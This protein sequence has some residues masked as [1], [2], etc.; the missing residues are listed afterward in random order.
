MG[1]RRLLSDLLTTK[2]ASIGCSTPICRE[3]LATIDERLANDAAFLSFALPLFLLVLAIHQDRAR[4][5]E[6]ARG[7]WLMLGL[8]GNAIG[9]AL[10]TVFILVVKGV[11]P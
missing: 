11:G 9:V 5:P 7:Q 6:N 10:L 1:P 8:L 4:N 2:T 3:I